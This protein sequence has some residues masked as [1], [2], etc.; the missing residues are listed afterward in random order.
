MGHLSVGGSEGVCRNTPRPDYQIH[1]QEFP[2]GDDLVRRLADHQFPQYAALPLH[3]RAASGSTN[4]LFRLGDR[5]LVRFPRQPGG[6]EAIHKEWRW[7]PAIG[8]IEDMGL[9]VL[10]WVK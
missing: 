4:A 7:L 2:L 1:D 3:R 10:V 8:W 9:Q 5:L 6:G